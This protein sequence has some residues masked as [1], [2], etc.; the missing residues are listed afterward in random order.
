MFS[1]LLL[2]ACTKCQTNNL[3]PSVTALL[4]NSVQYCMYFSGSNDCMSY[5]CKS[6]CMHL[7]FQKNWFLFKC[8][9][10]NQQTSLHALEI[11][12]TAYPFQGT[13]WCIHPPHFTAIFLYLTDQFN[14]QNSQNLYFPPTFSPYTPNDLQP[15][16]F[17]LTYFAIKEWLSSTHYY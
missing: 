15:T 5:T 4:L 10:N 8:I 3:V 17:Q 2:S 14:G 13:Q 11:V 6:K 12:H 16:F 7:H 1:N 9:M